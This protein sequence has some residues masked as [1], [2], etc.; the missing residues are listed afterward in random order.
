MNAPLDGGRGTDRDFGGIKLSA[1]TAD[2]VM[3]IVHSHL[4]APAPLSVTF[5]NPDYARRAFQDDR[6]RARVNAFDLVLVDGNGVRWLAPL[7]G[8]RVPE[9]LDTD[10]LA[11][12]LF[13]ELAAS[14]A[15]AFLFGCAPG[16]AERAADRL[17][18]ALP[19]L[20][21]VGTEHGYWDVERG[22]PG[23]YDAADTRRI[24][25]N[26]NASQADFLLVSLPTPLQQSW[27]IEHRSAIDASV[28]MTSG[29]FLDH[30]ADNEAWPESWYPEWANRY[31]LNW[32]YRLIREPRRLWK[33][34]TI[35]MAAFA[36]SA[37][38]ARLRRR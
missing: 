23:T 9:R 14:G 19:D 37:L 27:V 11:P 36:W 12:R 24:I 17:T 20:H 28:V 38:A 8:I 35:E 2:E 4:S 34:Y 15:R 16:V 5:V 7:F 30:V 31:S 18:A 25:E 32:F 1:I 29:S 13:S 22:H 3:H 10:G 33:R 6:L 26:I 21:I